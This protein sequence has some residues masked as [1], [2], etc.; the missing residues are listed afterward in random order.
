MNTIQMIEKEGGQY[1]IAICE[2]DKPKAG[3]LI[4]NVME[5][6]K[7]VARWQKKHYANFMFNYN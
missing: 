3:K 2:D 7:T 4:T 5:A 6:L 1:L